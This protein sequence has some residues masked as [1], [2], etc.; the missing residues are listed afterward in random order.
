MKNGLGKD[1]LIIFGTTNTAQIAPEAP[2]DIT[3]RPLTTLNTWL[4]KLEKTAV[5]R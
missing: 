2:S 3:L 5:E 1:I 4:Q